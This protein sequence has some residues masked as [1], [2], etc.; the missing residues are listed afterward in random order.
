M[1]P[2]ATGALPLELHHAA[3]E[4]ALLQQLRRGALLGHMAVIQHHDVV[5]PATVRILWAMTSTVLP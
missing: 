1:N 4:A 2:G 5:A 3:V